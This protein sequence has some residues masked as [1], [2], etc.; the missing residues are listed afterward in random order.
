MNKGYIVGITLLSTSVAFAAST[1]TTTVDPTTG[2]TVQSTTTDIDGSTTSVTTPTTTIVEPTTTTIQSTTTNVDGTTTSVTT[3]ADT[4]VVDTT[5]NPNVQVITP[6]DNNVQVVDDRV[7]ITGLTTAPTF[8]TVELRDGV[9][10]LPQTITPVNGFYFL[11]VGETEQVC[12]V[13]KI[14]KIKVHKISPITTKVLIRNKRVTLYCY[15]RNY[16]NF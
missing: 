16:F 14:K 10:Y 6:V 4:Q 11:T 12:T 7:S 5:V 3:P 15:D 9:Y 13:K 1:T 2:T 8:S